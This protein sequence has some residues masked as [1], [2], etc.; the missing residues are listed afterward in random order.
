MGLGGSTAKSAQIPGYEWFSHPKSLA[1]S[2]ELSLTSAV[3]IASVPL[4]QA[5]AHPLDRLPLWAGIGFACR[6]HTTSDCRYAYVATWLI[7]GRRVCAWCHLTWPF[8]SQAIAPERG[9]TTSIRPCRW[10]GLGQ[11]PL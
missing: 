1:M 6:W 9:L 8:G 2:V 7:G 3:V 11:P 4:S 5:A 10:P